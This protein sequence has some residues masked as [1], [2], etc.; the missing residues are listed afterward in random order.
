MAGKK[1][2]KVNLLF[3]R[4]ELDAIVNELIDLELMDIDEPTIP[5]DDEILSSALKTEY[6]DITEHDTNYES[7]TLLGTERTLYLTGWIW[8]KSEEQLVQMVSKYTCAWEIY[9]PTS[10]ELKS[11]PIM[12]IR[13]KFLFGLY[14][15]SRRLFYPLH[16]YDD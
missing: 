2:K 9:D 13:P 3:V 11:A 5:A 6:V 10:E 8:K 14:K 15:G 4:S 7:L 1:I 16:K 12:L